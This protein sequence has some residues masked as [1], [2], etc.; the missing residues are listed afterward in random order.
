MKSCWRKNNLGAYVCTLGT[1]E[2]AIVVVY[3]RIS[4]KGYWRIS[5]ASHLPFTGEQYE[6]EF[7]KAEDCALYAESIVLEWLNSLVA[8]EGQ[9]GIDNKPL[10]PLEHHE[11]QD[12]KVP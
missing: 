3:S 12:R 7:T 8:V 4:I 10:I 11:Q 2:K 9:K 1:L 6:K 5:M